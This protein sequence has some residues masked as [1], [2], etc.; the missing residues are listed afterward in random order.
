M[1][2]VLVSGS[3]LRVLRVLSLFMILSAGCFAQK[4]GTAGDGGDDGFT[5]DTRCVE[6]TCLLSTQV[7]G[8]SGSPAAA[9][10]PRKFVAIGVKLDRSTLKPQSFVFLVPSNAEQHQG[11]M[12]S[13]GKAKKEGNH[14]TTELDVHGASRIPVTSCN[15]DACAVEVPRGL[16]EEGKGSH[17][18]D[19]LYEFLHS[20]Y[21]V[22]LYRSEGNSHSNM[23]LLSPFKE[24]YE[25]VRVSEIAP[26]K[27][28]H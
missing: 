7:L 28:Q 14:W 17:K 1:T 12:I 21:F 22:F 27:A 5:W 24:A 16:L 18:T 26:P 13:F 23:V 2:T 15:K 3:T 19:L 25:K 11:V 6:K 10:D 4:T 8:E 9:E 20:E